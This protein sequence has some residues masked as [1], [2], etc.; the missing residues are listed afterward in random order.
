VK[1]SPVKDST[2]KHSTQRSRRRLR[3]ALLAAFLVCLPVA[4][5]AG[6]VYGP[7]GTLTARACPA[8]GP[9]VDAGWAAYRA[10]DMAGARARFEAA[11]AIC[12]ADVSA[13]VGLGYVALRQD[14][15]PAARRW[16]GEVLRADTAV[17]DASLGAGMV[18]WREGELEE[19]RRHFARVQRLEPG[20]QEARA[21]LARLPAPAGPPPRRPPLVLPDTVRF[22]AR[23]IGDRFEV[24]GPAGW[25][26]FYVKGVNIGAAMPGRYASEFP[27]SITYARWLEQIGAMGAN[28]VRLYTMHPPH[29]YGALRAHNLAHP[30][31]PLWLIHGVWAE[32]PPRDIVYDDPEWEA[33]FFQDIRWVVDIVHG[34]AD[35]P[36][37]PGRASGHYTADVSPWTFSYILGRE[38][39]SHSVAGFEQLRP[40]LTRFEGTYLRVERG[41]P[42]DVWMAKASEEMIAYEMDSYRA[43]RPLAYTNW[44]TTDALRHETE[45]TVMEEVAIRRSLGEQ[46][47]VRPVLE[48]DDAVTLD[49]ELVRPTAAFPAG[50]YA[51]YHV[52]PYYPDFMVLSPEYNRAVSPW[53]PSNYYGYLQDLKRHHRTMPV[54]I[55]EYGVPTSIGIAHVQPQGWHHGG[56]SEAEMAEIVVRMTD[57]IA[58]AGMAGGIVFAWIDE[59]FKKTWNTTEFEVPQDRGRLWYNRMDAEEHY[60]IVAMEPEERLAGRTLQER[61]AAWRSIPALYTTPDGGALR[62]MADEAYLRLLYQP[63]AGGAPSELHVGFD[64]IEPEAG[65]FRWPGRMGPRTPV[66]L[67]FVLSVTENEARVVADPRSNPTRVRELDARVRGIPIEGPRFEREPPGFFRGR[68]LREVQVPLVSRPSDD[69]VYDSLR[70]ITSRIRYG[71]DTTVYA[72]KGYDWGVLP[73]G[74]LPDGLWERGSGGEVEVRIPWQLLNVSDPSSRRVLHEPTHRYEEGGQLGAVVVDGIRIVALARH[75]G[76]WRQWPASGSRADVP[77]FTWD[78][79]EQPRWRARARPAYDALR[80]AWNRLD[81]PVLNEQGAIR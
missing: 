70:V 55:S 36:H 2:V 18:A 6:V 34:R 73:R 9:E 61:L 11:R 16:F 78:T 17:I 44:P 3:P 65:N 79:W 52:Y 47:E 30:R 39:E 46:I 69:G 37:R 81:A 64:T 28:T 66:G 62:A 53:G 10:N 31:N 22:P 24:R 19:S 32:L 1:R 58:A 35:I 54:L 56:N 13:R 23:A 74:P 21:Y 68:Y 25:E 51:S 63:P 41:T 12:P 76:E 80:D 60:G 48:G 38:W 77:L 20:N 27:D 67:E 45:S 71:R 15:L 26:P 7:A 29:F 5:G 40:E 59:W 33:E 43:Q 49:P 42:A 57:E 4:A 8:A 72:A 14:D 50:Y 75:G